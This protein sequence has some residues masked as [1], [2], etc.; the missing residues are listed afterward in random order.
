M[1]LSDLL[2]DKGK[3]PKAPVWDARVIG[4]VS[5]DDD[6]TFTGWVV[7][8]EGVKARRFLFTVTDVQEIK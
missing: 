7:E 5:W 2:K 4:P 3:A 6:V 1:T 8:N